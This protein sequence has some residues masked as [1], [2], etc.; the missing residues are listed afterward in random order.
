[1]INSDMPFQ[2][3]DSNTDLTVIKMTTGGAMT[4]KWEAH[5]HN[6]HKKHHCTE[7]S[8]SYIQQQIASKKIQQQAVQHLTSA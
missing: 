3:A 5:L 2:P 6:K 7:M 1:M 4:L 8:T